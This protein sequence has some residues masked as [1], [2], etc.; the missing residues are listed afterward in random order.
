MD[1]KNGLQK[2]T[3]KLDSEM[4]SL[5]LQFRRFDFLFRFD[6]AIRKLFPKKLFDC[7]TPT[8]AIK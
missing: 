5:F 6:S 7:P 2:W 8:L 3:P 4:D 1:S